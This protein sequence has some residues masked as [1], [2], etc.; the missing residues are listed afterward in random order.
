VVLGVF[1][2]RPSFQW[3]GESVGLETVL[4]CWRI[5]VQAFARTLL[6]PAGNAFEFTSRTLRESG[7]EHAID[8]QCAY[9]GFT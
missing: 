3:L 5:G 4:R 9:E 2:V 1:S 8:A 6:K 7:G